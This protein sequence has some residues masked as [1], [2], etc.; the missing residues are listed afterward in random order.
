MKTTKTFLT[1]LGLLFFVSNQLIA[2]D[3][4]EKDDR[5]KRPVR[6]PF[7]SAL[8]IDNQTV[9][10]PSAKTLEFD[11]NHRFGVIENGAS[12]FFGIY[13]PGANIRLGLTYSLIENLSIGIGYAKL[14]TYLDFSAKYAIFKQKR[15]WSMPISLTY[16]GNVAI[17]TRDANNFDKE[18]HRMS[19]F[20]E[21]IIAVRV[22]KKLSLQVTPSFS[23]FNAV[24]SLMSND[25][26]GVGLSGRYKFSSQSS[27]IFD[28]NQ[29]VTSHDDIVDVEPG[30]GLGL[31]VS[32]SAHAFQIFVSTFQG[33]L[34]QHNMVFSENKFDETGILIGFN[35]TRL[36]NF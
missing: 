4:E 21:L 10:V 24:D 17:D 35:I 18:V 33:I 30:I 12:D 32:T 8:L 20:N 36:W 6:D 7:E 25:I 11:M 9:I 34:P 23:H 16:F 22:N 5:D 29:Q 2:Q 19:Y 1:F 14:N 26:I 15:D 27:L 3:S 31:E 28:F 13:A